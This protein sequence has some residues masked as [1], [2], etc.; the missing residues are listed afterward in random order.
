MP[1]EV[2]RVA[3]RSDSDLAE[4]AIRMVFARAPNH[5][6]SVGAPQ[7]TN[8]TSILRSWW[9]DK[10]GPTF[11]QR[12]PMDWVAMLQNNY[13]RLG[14]LAFVIVFAGSFA[15]C[16][17]SGSKIKTTVGGGPGTFVE[18]KLVAD[19]AG[20]AAKTD[21]NLKNAWGM[22]YSPAGAFWIS[23]N[24]TGVSTLYDGS[25]TP[26]SLVVTIPA[27]GGGT[28]G[29]VTGQVFNSTAD[30]ALPGGG[31]TFFI[32]DSEDG[33]LT[34]WGG[35]GAATVVADRSASGAVYKGLA[36][37]S[38]GGANFLYAANF[39]SGSIDVF[40][41]SYTLTKSFTDPGIPAGY[42]P[43]GIANLGG[44]LYVTYAKQD[45]AKH[46]DVA[47]AGNGFVDVFQMDGTLVSKLITHG[48]LNSPWGLAIAPSGFG[49]LAGALLVGNFG[50]GTIHAFDGA[51]GA[52]LGTLSTKSGSPITIPGLWGLMF[53]NG[54]S[55]GP[56]TTLYFTAGPNGEA[57]GLFGS[58]TTSL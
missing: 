1:I 5:L 58:I 39:N 43:F 47:G 56:V 19:Q 40:D 57:N 4:K 10:L 52:S 8:R 53:G 32:F 26:Q 14:I 2:T 13:S 9:I 15:G 24:G 35:G 46:D 17:G 6:D 25:G 54:A 30:F 55:A 45:G 27:A 50:D 41:K 42:A 34:G 44:L 37:G 51:S 7:D 48:S 12:G 11:S 49:N 20:V 38:V 33:L 23:D 29:P 16:G 3:I 31:S 36:L 28:V 18:T 22:S 21:P